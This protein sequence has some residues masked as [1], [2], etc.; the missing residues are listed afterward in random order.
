MPV[1]LLKTQSDFYFLWFVKKI[2]RISQK[3]ILIK[4]P[5]VG[6]FIV[7]KLGLLY[8]NKWTTGLNFA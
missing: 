3:H 8:I 4:I 5:W 1:F 2:N 6:V 7:Q